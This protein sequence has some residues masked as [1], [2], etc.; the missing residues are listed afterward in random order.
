MADDTQTTI[1]GSTIS[2]TTFSATK[3]SDDNFTLQTTPRTNG[4][5]V[6]AAN[7]L[8]VIIIGGD[9]PSSLS[10]TGVTANGQLSGGVLPPSGYILYALFRETAGVGVNIAIGTTLGAS[11]VLAPQGVPGNGTLSVAITGFS[12]G[13]FSATVGQALYLTSASWGGASINA[14]LVYQVGP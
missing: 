14:T 10:T 4:A 6:T 13:W 3:D 8:P 2:A 1:L 12:L 7:P 11:D 5:E 9:V